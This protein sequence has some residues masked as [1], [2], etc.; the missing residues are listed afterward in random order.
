MQL[1]S[2]L[3]PAVSFGPGLAYLFIS[4]DLPAVRERMQFSRTDVEHRRAFLRWL[5]HAYRDLL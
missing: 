3:V 5:L 2:V 1:R 4:H